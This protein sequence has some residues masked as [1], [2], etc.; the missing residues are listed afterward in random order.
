MGTQVHALLDHS[1]HCPKTMSTFF[2]ASQEM[3]LWFGSLEVNETLRCRYLNRLSQ[4]TVDSR[5]RI[6]Q[7]WIAK[8]VPKLQSCALQFAFG[9]LKKDS[10]PEQ[11][12]CGR[13]VIC[14]RVA[15]ELPNEPCKNTSLKCL[16]AW[17]VNAKKALLQP[18]KTLV[19]SCWRQINAL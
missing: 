6:S 2:G 13:V 11:A 8:H 14:I 15:W 10:R 17:L 19:T 4:N 7:A 1:I 3:R 5:L 9:K 16:C 12:G 18:Y